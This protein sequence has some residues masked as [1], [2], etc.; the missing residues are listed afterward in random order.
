MILR[1]KLKVFRMRNNI[2]QKQLSEIVGITR[3]TVSKIET[4]DFDLSSS[5]AAKMAQFFGVGVDDIFWIE[6]EEE[7]LKRIKNLKEE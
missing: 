6:E 4:G 3:Q 5:T 7:D 1:N 2:T